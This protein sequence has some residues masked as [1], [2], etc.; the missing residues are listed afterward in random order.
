MNMFSKK[1]LFGDVPETSLKED[2]DFWAKGVDE[3][4]EGNYPPSTEEYTFN[5]LLIR[6]AIH[7]RMKKEKIKKID[8]LKLKK[9]DNKFKKLLKTD[10]ETYMGIGKEH[11]SKK[12]YWW[13]YGIPKNA[14]KEWSE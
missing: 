2:I 7:E 8:K 12:T 10:N 13:L 9:A 11:P 6:T 1:V 3:F 4:A 5:Y 14:P